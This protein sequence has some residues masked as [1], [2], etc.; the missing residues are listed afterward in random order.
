MALLSGGSYAQYATVHKDHI[1]NVPSN[2]TIEDVI[3][4]F[5]IIIILK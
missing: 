4:F 1:I 2:I 5:H 3:F